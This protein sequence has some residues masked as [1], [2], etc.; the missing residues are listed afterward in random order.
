MK[1]HR[2][3]AILM[4]LGMLSGCRAVQTVP[5]ETEGPKQT[6]QQQVESE[7]AAHTAEPTESARRPEAEALPEDFT[8]AAVWE[9]CSLMQK[10]GIEGTELRLLSSDT[11]E[12]LDTVWVPMDIVSPSTEHYPEDYQ[13]SLF[14]GVRWLREL[15]MQSGDLVWGE[16][17]LFC[18]EQG[19]IHRLYEVGVTHVS[20]D[21]DGLLLVTHRLGERQLVSGG[22]VYM[23]AGDRVVRL[24]ADGEPELLI[25]VRGW[26]LKLTKAFRDE[27]GAIYAVAA[28]P[29]GNASLETYLYRLE[30]GRLIACATEGGFGYSARTAEEA[31]L[32]QARL[33]ALS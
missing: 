1:Y 14:E 18:V 19:E 16:A 3:L 15:E 6:E 2:V 20:E 23:P 30:N 12:T 22:G 33:D 5:K 9:D 28:Q 24:D 31:A 17:G 7:P 11:G 27:D 25:D 26:D 13:Q 32:E 29:A 4:A 8:P 21:G 10:A